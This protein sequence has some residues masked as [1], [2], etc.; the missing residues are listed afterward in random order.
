MLLTMANIFHCGSTLQQYVWYG[1]QNELSYVT[2]VNTELMLQFSAE[3][4]RTPNHTRLAR[5]TE[6]VAVSCVSMNSVGIIKYKYLEKD[7][8]VRYS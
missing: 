1:E 2:S 6:L 3:V 5:I 4:T 8:D 7:G